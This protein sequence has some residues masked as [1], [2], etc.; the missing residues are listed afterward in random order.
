MN[1]LT[2]IG[3][4]AF[5]ALNT[6]VNAKP[7]VYTVSFDGSCDGFT[8]TYDK[9]QVLYAT[10][11]QPTC[12]DG[13]KYAPSSNPIPGVGI[14]VKRN[15]GSSNAR[16]IAVTE[17]TPADDGTGTAAIAFMYKLDYPLATGGAWAAYFTSD[18]KT[19]TKGASGTYTVH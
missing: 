7:K 12:A 5:L 14:V 8:M 10:L 11:H 16:D 3:V 9:G 17:T 18:G 2:T 4:V 13:A 6:A 15:P 19:I 1:K